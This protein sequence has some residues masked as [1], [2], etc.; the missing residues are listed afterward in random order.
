MPWRS[1]DILMEL[2]T[3][4]LVLFRVSGLMLTAPLF[5]SSM[6]PVRFRAGLAAIT[7]ALIFPLVRDQAPAELTLFG[8]V[9]GGV[10]EIM[11]GAIIGLALSGLL[12]GAEVGGLM[13]GR[14]AGLALANVFDPSSDE[15]ATVMGQL[16][17]IVMTFLFLLAGGHRAAMAALLDTF[18]VI[19]LL[20]FRLDETF[21]L[22]IV[23]ILAAAFIL[24]IRLAG[25]VLLAL[26]MMG[27]ALGF[28]SRTMPQLN[29]LTVGFTLRLLLAFLV[30]GL[31]ISVSQDV[32]LDAIWDSVDLIRVTFGLDPSHHTLV[33]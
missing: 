6:V 2:P 33:N 5:K 8:A 1:L 22:L 29:I 19:P 17:T 3:Y 26:F 15:Q 21:V 12:M 20:T 18:E 25:P 24:G 31:A 28:L 23:E 32:L 4:A 7:A 10:S 11:V 9:V 13:I 16:Y 27:T 30:A 14:Q